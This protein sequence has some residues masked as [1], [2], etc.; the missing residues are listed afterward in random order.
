MK[1][2]LTELRKTHR[3]EPLAFEETLDLKADLMARYGDEVLDLTP[4]K[5]KG[6]V[7]VVSEGDVV[8]VAQIKATLTVPSS[9]SLAP[10]T[11]PVDF[12]MTEYYVSDAAATQRFEKTDVVMVVP[13]DV[14]DFDKAVGDNLILQIP[15]HI[16]SD[17]EKQGAAMPEGTGW[18]VVSEADLAKVE[19]ENQTVDPRLAKL[20]DFFPDQDDK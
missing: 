19:A 9:R 14:I 4:V 16:L 13:D 6:L 5:A 11:L 2:S 18:Q 17:T 20:K 7:S 12:Q 3:S 10:V 8:V 15:M 1:W